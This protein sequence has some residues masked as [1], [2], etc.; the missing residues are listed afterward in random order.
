[1]LKDPKNEKAPNDPKKNNKG[2]DQQLLSEDGKRF[3]AARDTKGGKG[4]KGPNLEGGKGDCPRCHGHHPE[5]RDCPN[6]AATAEDGFDVAAHSKERKPCWYDFMK[7]GRHCGGFGH[8]ARHHEPV[9]KPESK[10]EI[11]DWK[12]GRIPAKGKRAVARAKA[13][14]KKELKERTSDWT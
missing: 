11:D 14:G 3:R 8:V 6:S 1:M 7:R 4:A 5:C 2:T 12:A 10:K 9:L 13:P